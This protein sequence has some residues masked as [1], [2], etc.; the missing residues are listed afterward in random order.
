VERLAERFVMDSKKNK[1]WPIAPVG[2][3]TFI[4]I[5]DGRAEL[6]SA[7]GELK[8]GEPITADE[9]IRV[10]RSEEGH[11]EGETL[12][13]NDRSPSG[14]PRVNMDKYRRS[15]GRID[16]SEKPENLPN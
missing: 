8:E 7:V 1:R 11:L 14:T 9:I 13:K 10:S 6:C 4:R 2:E 5:L 16:W 12:F 15:Y 3:G